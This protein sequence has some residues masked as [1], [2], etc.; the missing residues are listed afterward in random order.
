MNST[1]MIKDRINDTPTHNITTIQIEPSDL[2][3]DFEM[4][5]SILVSFL[6][7]KCSYDLYAAI[8]NEIS[9]KDHP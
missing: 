6:Q 7:N 3:I 1:M 2:D 8:R 4:E 9:R 5:A